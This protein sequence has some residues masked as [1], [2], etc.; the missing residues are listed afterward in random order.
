VVE[1]Q[2]GGGV[3]VGRVQ[4]ERALV[5]RNGFLE[6]A[7]NA[8]MSPLLTW[9]QVESGSRASAFDAPDRSSVASARGT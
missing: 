6:R 5:L 9:D 4:C 8:R 1:G 3:H 7:W 2:A